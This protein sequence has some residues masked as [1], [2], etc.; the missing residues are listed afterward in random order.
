MPV[1]LLNLKDAEFAEGKGPLPLGP[2]ISKAFTSTASKVLLISGALLTI[3]GLGI[4]LYKSSEHNKLVNSV[5]TITASVTGCDAPHIKVGGMDVYQDYTQIRF[6][7]NVGNRQYDESPTSRGSN[8]VE[9][10]DMIRACKSGTNTILLQYLEDEPGRWAAAPHSP[11]KRDEM[12]LQFNPAVLIVGLLLLF[13]GGLYW[14]VTRA[15][16]NSIARRKRLA[17][18]GVILPAELIKVT[19]ADQDEYYTMNCDYQF[20]NPQGVTMKGSTPSLRQDVG[21][22][23]YPQAGTPMLVVYVNDDLFEAL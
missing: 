16:R 3:A 20:K 8:Y 10:G 17:M 13:C 21:V 4:Y 11:L 6:H 22:D 9:Q 19:K 1:F 14:L 15:M 5:R 18:E 7:Y 12:E 2:T 23:E